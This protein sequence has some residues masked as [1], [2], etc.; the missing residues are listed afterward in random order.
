[1]PNRISRSLS[2][3]DRACAGRP[4][5]STPRCTA[6]RAAISSNQ[7]LQV[8]VVGQH[9]ALVLPGAQPGEGGDVGDRIL[10]AA[11]VLALRQALV[12]HAVEA[13]GLVGVAVDRVRR[14]SRAR[15]GGSGGPGRASAR[16]RPSGTSATAA[17]RTC[18]RSACGQELAGLGRRGTP[19]SRPTRTA[20]SACRPGPSGSTM[21][22]IL[23]FGLIARNSGLNWSP[24]PMLT[25]MR[26][27]RQAALLQHDV[28]LVAV[29]RGPGIHFDHRE[30]SRI[31]FRLI[32]RL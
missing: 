20:R 3:R 4:A 32:M 25:G 18:A 5:P 31:G 1:M 24:A 27:V 7:S 6:G 23:L 21:A 12:D 8:R 16:R 2:S 26:A 11:E 22:G 13:L 28:D 19:G 17:P 10:V 9:D 14:S 29:G 15:R 30:A